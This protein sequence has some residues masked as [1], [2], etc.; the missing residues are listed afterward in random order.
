MTDD[1]KKTLGL[2]LPNAIPDSGLIVPRGKLPAQLHADIEPSDTTKL[3]VAGQRG[4]GKT[5]ELRRLTALLQD[6]DYLPVFLQFGAQPSITHAGLIRAMGEALLLHRFS[7]LNVKSFQHFQE[8]YL[9]EEVT[10]VVEEGTR[11][12]A[13]LGGEY[14]VFSAKGKLEHKSSRKTKKI[15]KVAKDTRELIIRFNRLIQ[16]V[17]KRTGKRVVFIVDD[18]DKVQDS[19][20]IDNT[21]IH[22]SHFIGEIDSPCIFTV[23]I[24]YATSS[25]L[26]IAALPYTGIYRVPAVELLDPQ[27]QRNHQAFEFMRKVFTL[28]MPFNPIPQPLFDKVLEYSGGV[29][30]DAMRMFRCI[31]KRV[32]LEPELAVNEQVVLEEFQRLVDDYKFVFDKPSLWQKLSVM[33]KAVDK[34]IIM[35]DDALPELL[36]KMIVIEYW[37]R[38]VWFDLHPAARALYGQHQQV[39][40]NAVRS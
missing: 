32:I 35:I 14:V 39:I 3:L 16:E 38:K 6:S 31:C 4:M 21:F 27:G 22:A 2:L 36:Y 11:G 23:P 33:C 12:E 19:S 7:K 28:R 13:G 26:R 8:W 15:Q 10:H 9:R 1:Q 18:I 20:S 29:L 34:Q 24:T 40:D 5:T 37:D 30:I 17:R 25:Y